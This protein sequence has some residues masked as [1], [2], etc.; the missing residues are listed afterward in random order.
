MTE[1]LLTEN[2]LSEGFKSAYVVDIIAV[3]LLFG[4][5]LQ[6]A[7]RGAIRM[8]VGFV[9]TAAAIVL[10][11][12]FAGKCAEYL[13]SWF[14]LGSAIGRGIE[15]ALLKIKGFDVDL[16]EAGM[17]AALEGV[18]LPSFIKDALLDRFA[19]SSLPKGTTLAQK[20]GVVMGGYVMRVIS[21]VVVFLLVK[22]VLSIL[23]KLL[24]GIAE[25]VTLLS[26]VN[27]LL[28]GCI[29]VLKAFVVVCGVLA[30]ASLLPIEAL[31]GFLNDTFFIQY[32]YNDN[33]LMRLF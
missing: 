31:N 14:S 2:A 16:S 4:F 17:S 26:A 28:G 19:D 8:L 7:R 24:S 29:G 32:L 6:G 3:A 20:A 23:S 5:C 12:L 30:I 33:P 9:S 15:G 27:S 18:N 25:R 1:F 10:A 11:F 13:E 22:F 21:W